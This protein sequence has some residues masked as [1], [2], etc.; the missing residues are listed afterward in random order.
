MILS[1]R[2]SFQE[3]CRQGTDFE[4]QVFTWLKRR[5]MYNEH[6]TRL[7][8]EFIFPAIVHSVIKHETDN[9]FCSMMRFMPDFLVVKKNRTQRVVLVEAKNSLYLER[10]A[11]EWYSTYNEWIPLWMVVCD[12]QTRSVFLGSFSDMELLPAFKTNSVDV[13]DG[14]AVT[15][16]TGSGTPFRLINTQSM[17]RL[18]DFW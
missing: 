17:S 4:E 16:H 14:W 6:V 12:G 7:G 3:R 9:A 1:N 13:V 10:E 8:A 5:N 18:H 11:Y 2:N 15:K